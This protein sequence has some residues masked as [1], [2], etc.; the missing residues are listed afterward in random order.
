MSILA[1]SS[2]FLSLVLYDVVLS[3]EQEDPA[4]NILFNFFALTI[5]Q[6]M[7]KPDLGPDRS[8]LF[9]ME[10]GLCYDLVKQI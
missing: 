9:K 4:V 1:P 7:L 8:Y 5:Q 10:V 2:V 6:Y 3:E